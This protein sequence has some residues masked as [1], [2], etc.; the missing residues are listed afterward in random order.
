MICML[1]DKKVVMTWKFCFKSIGIAK[2]GHAKNSIVALRTDG[3]SGF[4]ERCKENGK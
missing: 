3:T 1:F 4:D 2:I